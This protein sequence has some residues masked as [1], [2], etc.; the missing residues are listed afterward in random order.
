MPYLVML[1]KVEKWSS[2]IR[3]TAIFNC[4][5]WTD[6]RTVTQRDHKTGSALYTVMC[7]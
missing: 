5:L 2:E 4:G 6:R 3:S 1:R 7:R